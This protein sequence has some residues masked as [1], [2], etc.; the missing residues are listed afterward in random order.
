MFQEEVGKKDFLEA[1]TGRC[2]SLVLWAARQR[3]KKEYILLLGWEQAER[4]RGAFQLFGL[5]VWPSFS[6]LAVQWGHGLGLPTGGKRGLEAGLLGPP[7]VGSGREGM[8]LRL[9]GA[10]ESTASC[11]FFLG[12]RNMWMDMEAPLSQRQHTHTRIFL[13]QIAIEAGDQGYPLEIWIPFAF[14]KEQL[15]A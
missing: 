11:G 1:F 5:V 10:R 3:K 13:C 9:G 8:W 2:E 4:E 12:P 7:R 6:L 14:G 15:P